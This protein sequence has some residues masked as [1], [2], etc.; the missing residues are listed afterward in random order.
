MIR[1]FLFA[2]ATAA[3]LKPRR[4]TQ[5]WSHRLK[6]S[7]LSPQYFSTARAPMQWDESKWNRDLLGFYKK[8]IAMRNRHPSLRV[9]SYRTIELGEDTGCFAFER[10]AGDEAVLA[11]IHPGEEQ[12]VSLPDDIAKAVAA[13]PDVLRGA[14]AGMRDDGKIV[15]PARAAW[16]ISR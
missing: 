8:I 15:L 3:L 5:R 4:S 9:G 11:L 16:I 10:R 14:R 13:N 1:A 7:L 2:K 12:E 6:G